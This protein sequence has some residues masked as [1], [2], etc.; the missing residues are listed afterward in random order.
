MGRVSTPT[1]LQMEATECG[2]ACLAILLRHY[3]RVVSLLEL[4]QVCGV[5]R[6]GSDAA[7]LLRAAKLYGLEGKGYRIDLEALRKQQPPLIVFWEFNHF[8]VLE[9]FR[10]NRVALND[11]ATGPRWVGLQTFSAGFTGVVLQLKPGPDFRRGG[12]VSSAWRLL[13]AR[14]RPE[15]RAALFGWLAGLLLILPQLAMPIFTQ[16]Y[17]DDVWGSALSHWLKPMLWAMALT[18][19]LQAVGGQLQLLGNRHL[20]RRLETRGALAFETHALALPD[21]FFRQR[22][23]GDVSQRQLLN[24]DVAEFIAQRLLPLLSGLLLLLLYLL[25]T[26]AYSPLLGLVVALSTA[27]NALL[28]L[29][30]LRQ[31]RDA[32][33]TLQK[34]A[35]KA[36]G[37]LMAALFEIDMV[38]STA[39]ESDVL[40]RFAGFQRKAQS[41]LHRLSLRQAALGLLP[42]L[43]NQLNTLGVLF[44][45][46]LLVLDGRLTLG[47]LLAAQ[48]VAAGLKAEVDRLVA[49]VT[50]LPQIETAVLR[51]HDVLDHPLDPLLLT[52]TPPSLAPWPADRDQL[53]G[54]VDIDELTYSFAPVRPPLIQ[55]LSFSI[56]PGMRVALV[57]SS[58]SGKST[59]ARLIAGLLQ[60]SAGRIL[61]DG[62]PLNA[63]PRTVVTAS[64]AMVQQEIAIYGM[65]LRDNLRLWRTDL[66]DDQL[67]EACDAAQLLEVIQSLPD[68]LDTRLV[69]GG[70]N[71]SGGQ[72]QRLEL[73]R[74]LLQDPTLLILDEATSALDAETEQRVEEALRR[75]AFSQ[76]VVAHRLS[77]IRDADLILVLDCG[78]VVQRGS[79][80]Q[81]IADPEG[82]YAR[83]LAQGEA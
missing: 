71:L 16:I 75:R 15:W 31:Q 46:F 34:D 27:L 50:D 83:L 60:P 58:G 54:Q 70:R 1:V 72:R 74:A 56:R 48:Q 29:I 2:A 79:H 6:D 39:I 19:V 33:L 51:L 62:Y 49:F 73:A 80:R 3:G 52:T 81:L 32:T 28:V 66:T 82:L 47:M 65:S 77:T 69:E 38:K 25:L 36:E 59:L 22:Y 23:A 12:S 26:L 45:G 41:F 57:G 24:R 76:V 78:E 17:I 21:G 68:G 9:G 7:S 30:S 5:T 43:L 67:L 40:Q 13:A 42:N 61:F 37:T 53:S 35:G 8:L 55:H 11:P 44:V 20:S 14:L 18:I 64:L 63:I 4:R 10:G